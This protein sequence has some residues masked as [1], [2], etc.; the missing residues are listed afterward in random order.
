[1]S[2]DIDKV[3]IDL[4][5]RLRKFKEEYAIEFQQRLEAKTPVR[6]GDMKKGWGNTIKQ[7]GFEVWNTQDYAG[8]VN[9]GTP[10]QAP[11]RM[12]ERTAAE[13]E[14][15]AKVAARKAGLKK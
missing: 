11:Q 15:I 14:A 13:G 6:S 1:M 3:F 7:E 10:Y 4:G 8:Y 2:G 5:T 12:I 9:Y